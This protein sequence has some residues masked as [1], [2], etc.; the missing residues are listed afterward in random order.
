[1]LPDE[2]ARYDSVRVEF[3]STGQRSVSGGRSGYRVP[4]IAL[5]RAV[6]ALPAAARPVPLCVGVG[7]IV[8]LLGKGRA[9]AVE[10]LL[11]VFTGASR[12]LLSQC[13]PFAER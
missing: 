12:R 4:G 11:I 2:A 10:G 5:R 1:M 13:D 3:E 6:T 8:G 9:C 7:E